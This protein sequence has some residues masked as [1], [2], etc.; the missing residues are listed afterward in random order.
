MFYTSRTIYGHACGPQYLLMSQGN[1][2]IYSVNMLPGPLPPQRC[3]YWTYTQTL[4]N[5]F[6]GFRRILGQPIQTDILLSIN[7]TGFT[8]AHRQTV[9]GDIKVCLPYL[10]SSAVIP[11]LCQGGEKV[12]STAE[13]AEAI[14]FRLVASDQNILFEGKKKKRQASWLYGSH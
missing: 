14:S 6:C 2:C 8:I 4:D 10:L 13:M 5:T 11:F 7:Q 1:V 9:H 12:I 3:T